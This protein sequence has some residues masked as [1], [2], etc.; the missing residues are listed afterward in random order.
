VENPRLAGRDFVVSELQP[1]TKKPE[2]KGRLLRTQRYKYVAFSQV[3]NPEMLFD[4]KADPGETSN[5]AR[6]PSMKDH[7]ERHRSLLRRWVR[8][9][10]DQF[11]VP[12]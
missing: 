2:M 11:D 6:R 5:L 4:L 9:T 7:L 1:D 12:A 3:K 8:R 10:N